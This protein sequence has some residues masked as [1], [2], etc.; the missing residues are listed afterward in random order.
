MK[1]LKESLLGDMEVAINS[2]YIY[3]PKDRNELIEAIKACLDAKIYDLNCIDTSKITDMSRLFD[4]S[5]FY[6]SNFN[7]LENYSKYFDKINISEWDV[8]NVEEMNYMFYRSNFNCDISK[9]NVY[10]VK[11]M[12][13]MFA[14][15][16]FNGN[17]S[18]WDVSNV[19][20]MCYMFNNSQFNGDISKWDVSNVEDMSYMF[21]ESKFNGNI[22][23][24]DVSNVKTMS[25]MFY[26]S[27]FN[28]DISNWNISN[29]DYTVYMFKDCPIK[30][31]YKPNLF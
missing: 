2:K 4:S 27:K 5:V 10:N 30:E 8:S 6:R 28:G 31:K 29:V 15:S 3:Y 11:F 23:K 9:W 22:S 1:S 19:K 26:R 13:Y 7:P 20:D 18:K 14:E 12:S 24:W 16:K 21:A 25:Y 17:I